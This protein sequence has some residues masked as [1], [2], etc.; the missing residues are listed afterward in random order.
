MRH[1]EYG[2]FMKYAAMRVVMVG[3]AQRTVSSGLLIGKRDTP[4]LS[5]KLEQQR[6]LWHDLSRGHN[7]AARLCRPL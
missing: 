2:W 7:H 6:L 1:K 3:G 5:S 4:K